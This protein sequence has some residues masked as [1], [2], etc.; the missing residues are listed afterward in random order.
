LLERPPVAAR[1]ALGVRNSHLSF[2]PLNHLR[3]SLT[4]GSPRRGS[5]SMYLQ[6]SCRCNQI[7]DK[8]TISGRSSKGRLPR[9]TADSM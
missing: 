5:E 2:P 6:G 9:G 8:G 1:I 7:F 4:G 3:S